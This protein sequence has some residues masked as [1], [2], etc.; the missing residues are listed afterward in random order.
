M[1]RL[2]NSLNDYKAL[3]SQQ[4]VQYEFDLNQFGGSLV[5]TETCLEQPSQVKSGLLF[6]FDLNQG[7][8]IESL[9][10]CTVKDFLTLISFI[11]ISC[12]L[13]QL[14]LGVQKGE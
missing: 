8:R 6:H 9:R 11:Q 14:C 4:S 3:W 2:I 13:L 5:K 7:T 12:Y 10:V 1:L